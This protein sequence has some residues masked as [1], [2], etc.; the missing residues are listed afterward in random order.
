FLR[1]A[2]VPEA[3]TDDPTTTS[4]AEHSDQ[5]LEVEVVI[6]TAQAD[7]GHLDGQIMPSDGGD[8]PAAVNFVGAAVDVPLL[9]VLLELRAGVAQRRAEPLL[10]P[11]APGFL[12]GPE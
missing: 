11:V 1:H 7:P 9:L 12:L 2:A 4:L 6:L 8:V 3:D 5:A 10:V